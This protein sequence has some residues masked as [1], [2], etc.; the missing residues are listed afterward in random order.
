MTM[1]PRA[2]LSLLESPDVPIGAHVTSNDLDQERTVMNR[3]IAIGALLTSL[4]MET[5]VTA[6]ELPKEERSATP[7]PVSGHNKYSRS[8]TGLSPFSTSQAVR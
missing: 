8:E 5:V 3:T 4:A 2:V 6:A 7:T 1:L